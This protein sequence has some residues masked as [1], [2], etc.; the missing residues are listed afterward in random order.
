MKGKKQTHPVAAGGGG[1]CRSP[2]CVSA[3]QPSRET[4]RVARQ[5]GKR[6]LQGNTKKAREESR[7][8]QSCFSRAL[9][10]ERS[11]RGCSGRLLLSRRLLLRHARLYHVQPERRKEGQRKKGETE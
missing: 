8:F 1:C 3:A 7:R 10:S 11:A 9:F 6:D 5:N 2:L 4:E